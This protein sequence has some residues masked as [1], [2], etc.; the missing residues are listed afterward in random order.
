MDKV[1]ILWRIVRYEG[2]DILGVFKTK[3]RARE[4]ALTYIDESPYDWEADEWHENA[5]WNHEWLWLRIDNEFVIGE[6]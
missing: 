4:F 6:F 2:K 3:E 1:Y 5:W